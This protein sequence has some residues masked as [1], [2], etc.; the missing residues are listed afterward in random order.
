MAVTNLATTQ[1]EHTRIMSYFALDA[2]KAA[3]KVAIDE[4]NP[5]MGF[6]T[7]RAGMHCGPVVGHVVGSKSPRYSLIGDSVNIASRM[8]S[9]SL[10]GRLHC[11]EECATRLMEQSPDLNVVPRGMVRRRQP[12]RIL[13]HGESFL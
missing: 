13:D 11:T 2:I 6:V 12:N 9:N 8:E 7:I 10:P 1:P 3:S 5:S 4:E